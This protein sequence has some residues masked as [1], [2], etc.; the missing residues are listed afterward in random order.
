MTTTNRD[1]DAVARAAPAP[2]DFLRQATSDCHQ[3]LEAAIDWPQSLGSRVSYQ[4][5][6]CRFLSVVQPA[7][8]RLAYWLAGDP[9][10]DFEAGRRTQ[11]LL[12][13][14]ES[15]SVPHRHDAVAAANFHF[16]DTLAAAIGAQYV[17]EGSSLGGQFLSRQIE[18]N[19]SITPANGGAYFAAYGSET[20]ERWKIFRQWANQ[21]LTAA[22]TTD[23][24]ALTQAAEAAVLVFDRFHD[25]IGRGAA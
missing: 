9:P 20:M 21:R 4:Q 8:E 13:D 3:R 1:A 14:L 22:A 15:L 19:L 5:L 17:L 12:H 2:L 25:A 24:A 10:P 7:E 18:R 23:P 11:W 16:I 6:L